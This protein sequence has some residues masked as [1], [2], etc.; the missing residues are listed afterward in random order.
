MNILNDI[1]ILD[2]VH[3]VGVFFFNIVEIGSISV[4]IFK[5]VYLSGVTLK[6]LLLLC[7]NLCLLTSQ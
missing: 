1:N 5:F 3:F 4:I 6:E 7:G 2:A